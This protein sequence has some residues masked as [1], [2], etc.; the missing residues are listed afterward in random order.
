[1]GLSTHRRNLAVLQMANDVAGLKGRRMGPLL[2][3]GGRRMSSCTR[4]RVAAAWRPNISAGSLGL[5]RRR[6]RRE[7]HNLSEMPVF[8]ST[9]TAAPATACQMDSSEENSELREDGSPSAWLERATWPAGVAERE[10]WHVEA[11][12]ILSNFAHGYVSACG[13][14]RY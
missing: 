11:Q 4:M 10:L 12:I 13:D 5:G 1:M 8:G 3:S 6:I 9:G 14:A 2:P 7:Q